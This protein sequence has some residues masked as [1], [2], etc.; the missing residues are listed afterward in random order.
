VSV[1]AAEPVEQRPVHVVEQGRR[2]DRKPSEL[3]QIGR[4]QLEID[5]PQLDQVGA[6]PAAVEDLVLNGL[7][8]LPLRDDPA[9]AQDA[10][11]YRQ[12]APP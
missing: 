6:Q 7:L 3:G 11:E 1:V 9:I 10:S 2:G 4:Q 12:R 8:Q 5:E